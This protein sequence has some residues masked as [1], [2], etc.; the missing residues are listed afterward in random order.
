MAPAFVKLKLQFKFEL[1]D[2]EFQLIKIQRTYNNFLEKI[3]IYWDN[4]SYV[5]VCVHALVYATLWGPIVPQDSKNL[6]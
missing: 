1:R 5:H 4:F 6:T 2:V 3:K